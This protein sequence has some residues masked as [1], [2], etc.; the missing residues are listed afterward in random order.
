MREQLQQALEQVQQ[1]R[2]EQTAE[3]VAQIKALPRTEEG[4]FDLSGLG[5]AVEIKRMLYPVYA[6]YETG[7]NKKEGYADILQQMRVLNAQ[8]QE[9]YEMLEAAVFMDTILRTLMYV[10]PEIYECYR[11]LV[12]IYRDNVH[13]FIRTFYGKGGLQPGGVPGS[14]AEVLFIG[15]LMLACKEYILL[16]EKYEVFFGGMAL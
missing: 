8:L 12:D 15:S 9:H 16:K 14:A 13:R 10:S 7:C 5:D 11:E 4:V 1:G 6:A 3:A 2:A